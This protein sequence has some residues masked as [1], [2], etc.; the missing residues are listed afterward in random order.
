VISEPWQLF[1]F[2]IVF[3]AAY[4]GCGLVPT[5]TI[6]ARW[7]ERQRPLALS[8]AST[9]LSLGG[10]ICTPISALLILHLGL[11]GA[12]PWIA[13]IFF[14]GVVPV[15]LLVI[16]AGPQPMGLLPDGEI[17]DAANGPRAETPS[18]PFAVVLRSRYFIVIAITFLF[19]LGTQVGGIAHIFRLVSTRVDHETATAAMAMFALSSLVG[20]LT[21]GWMLLR[22]SSRGMTYA[23]IAVQTAS[24]TGLAFAEGAVPLVVMV[25]L[26]ALT[27][28]SMLMM[29]PLLLAEAFGVKHYG[30]IYSANQL[31]GVVGYA[32]GPALIG[33]LYETSGGYLVAYLAVAAIS[34]L[35]MGVLALSGRR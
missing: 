31:V 22:I 23:L 35:S 4:G 19:A 6:V 26:F 7:F 34:F 24:L 25:F 9:G 29:Q 11:A 8:I 1:A 5:T 16:R 10:I 27:S 18:T 32:L 14:L 28:G 17:H 13:L 2:Y 3:G 12:A 33:V 30:R 15:T 20:R 21:V